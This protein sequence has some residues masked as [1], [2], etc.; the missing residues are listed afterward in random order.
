MSKD[1]KRLERPGEVIDFTAARAA[2]TEMRTPEQRSAREITRDAIHV[3]TTSQEPAHILEAWKVLE[4]ERATGAIPRAG[5]R[6]MDLH[7][8]TLNRDIIEHVAKKAPS[9]RSLVETLATQTQGGHGE[10][11]AAP[12]TFNRIGPFVHLTDL[13]ERAGGLVVESDANNR[14]EDEHRRARLGVE[15]ALLSTRMDQLLYTLKNGIGT[16]LGNKLTV[17]EKATLNDH[18]ERILH[19]GHWSHPTQEMANTFATWES[20]LGNFHNSGAVA[21]VPEPASFRPKETARAEQKKKPRVGLLKNIA[22]APRD[23][24]NEFVKLLDDN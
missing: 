8:A 17:L 2:R 18:I 6:R 19:G 9:A 14:T 10:P 20:I 22:N 1:G 13:S 3:A 5:L 24:W 23:A 7:L 4:T 12:V 11:E 21:I 16:T 15:V